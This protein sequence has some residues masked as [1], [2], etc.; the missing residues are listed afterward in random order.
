[1]GC[2]LCGCQSPAKGTKPCHHA[3]PSI[4][5]VSSLSLD[6][7]QNCS[8]CQG[9]PSPSHHWA[10]HPPWFQVSSPWGWRN[11]ELCPSC[12]MPGPCKG[13]GVHVLFSHLQSHLL[14]MPSRT[15]K[16]LA[17]VSWCPSA[18]KPSTPMTGAPV[19]TSHLPYGLSLWVLW[20]C[21]HS[22]VPPC[23]EGTGLLETPLTP[24]FLP[25]GLDSN[26][27]SS[28]QEFLV[29]ND[30]SVGPHQVPISPDK[31]VPRSPRCSPPS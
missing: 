11:S 26:S 25:P 31:A 24:P 9:T 4:V 7:S 18:P 5:C 29:P 15:R 22:N 8:K 14:G 16:T 17:L 30:V 3:C 6:R 19:P 13:M 12:S 1:M 2:A 10:T 20:V 23:L 27:Q 28:S 21:L